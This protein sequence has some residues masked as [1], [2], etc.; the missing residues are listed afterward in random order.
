MDNQN[1]TMQ[2][3]PGRVTSPAMYTDPAAV[4]SAEAAKARIQAAYTMAMYRPRNYDQSRVNI[5]AACK[6]PAFAEK[7]TYSKPVGSGKFISGPSIRLAELALREWGNITYENAVV[8]DDE[9]TR[10]VQ[11]VIT[12]LETNTTFSCAIQLNKT[13]ERKYPD[14]TRETLSERVNSKG[15]KTYLVRA[16]EDE[17]LTRQAALVS[18][19]LR[20]EG[21]RLIPQE[22]VEEALDTAEQTLNDRDAKDPGAA[23]RKLA[24]AFNTLGI[25]PRDLEAYL[26][27]PVAQCNRKEIS[28]LRGMFVALRDGDAKWADFVAP[29]EAE[30]GEEDASKKRSDKIL[31]K[32]GTA[33]PASKAASA[34]K[35]PASADPGP[36]FTPPETNEEKPVPAPASNR[37]STTMSNEIYARFKKAHKGDV[38][39]AM[40]DIVDQ[41]GDKHQ[42]EWTMADSGA[43]LGRLKELESGVT[44]D[45][46]KEDNAPESTEAP[47][48]DIFSDVAGADGLF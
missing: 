17:V 48:K 27:H 25:K 15:E 36:E 41:I 32:N 2:M 34:P 42:A 23:H 20:N 12:D 10:R 43:L 38:V 28:E 1:E 24:D 11:V 40:S 37:M 39:L 21:L 13:V 30:V 4:A 47:T 9:R 46:P 7:V 6:R 26:K 22:I 44:P 19:A 3:A 5:M 29:K 45:K 35:A 33:A 18:K 16:T 14:K 8:Y 31:G